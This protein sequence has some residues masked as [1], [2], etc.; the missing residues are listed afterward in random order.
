MQKNLGESHV[1]RIGGLLAMIMLAGLSTH[2]LSN[3]RASTLFDL[4]ADLNRAAG[5]WAFDAPSGATVL[6]L[7]ANGRYMLRPDEDAEATDRRWAAQVRQS[8]ILADQAG[9]PS[10]RP[11]VAQASLGLWT[12]RLGDGLSIVATSAS[13]ALAFFL[14]ALTDR[15]PSGDL[16]QI[17]RALVSQAS[18]APRILAG[19]T[20]SIPT[21][22]GIVSAISTNPSIEVS[23]ARISGLAQVKAAP[24]AAPGYYQVFFYDSASRFSPVASTLIEVADAGTIH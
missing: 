23:I 19:T 13:E 12:I 4:A 17:T 18:A 15:A 22:P 16:N 2:P 21:L 9:S 3:A 1:T 8:L 7:N 10:Q 24:E 5:S 6:I 11:V 20:E 14:C